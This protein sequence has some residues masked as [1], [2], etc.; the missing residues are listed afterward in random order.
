MT[1][2]FKKLAIAAGVS[3]GMAALS[4]PSH[5]SIMGAAGEALLV[6]LVVYATPA[7]SG[8][9]AN[10]FVQVSTPGAI[11]FDDV[12]N[13]FISPNTTPT[14]A[15]ATLF[16]L[17]AD[18][19]SAT[20]GILHWYWFDHRSIHRLDKPL[21]VTPNDV[22]TIDWYQASRPSTKYDGQAGYMVVGTET[23][24]RGEAANFNMFGEAWLAMDVVGVDGFNE[25][26]ASLATVP[27]YPMSDGADGDFLTLQDSVIYK[28]GIP[29]QVS[30]LI[31]GVRTNRSDGIPDLTAFD[32]TLLTRT[33]PSMHV[34]WLDVN[35]DEVD[36]Y[37]T[38]IPVDVYDSD[39]VA[40]SATVSLKNE[41][42]VIWIDQVVAPSGVAVDPEEIFFAQTNETLCVPSIDKAAS[43]TSPSFATY[44]LDEYVDTDVDRPESA[45]VAFNLVWADSTVGTNV[46]DGEDTIDGPWSYT[47]FGQTM[48]L[49]HDR[50]SFRQ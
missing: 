43:L 40:C 13:I 19:Q 18:L 31:A 47:N 37:S 44:Y 1:Q 45:G 48:F 41:L 29:N 50:G 42:N 11:G 23:A 3:V 12:P 4:M 16:P 36:G 6:P 27:V 34:V 7:I 22:V 25:A 8:Y 14:N 46:D 38:D 9:Y 26:G 20:T 28:G 2:N 5:A 24:R 32:M 21:R 33:Q 39:E 35:L 30:P 10:T 49:A 17:D 15:D